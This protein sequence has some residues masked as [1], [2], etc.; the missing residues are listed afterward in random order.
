[1]IDEKFKSPSTNPTI[2]IPRPIVK[3]FQKTAYV[4][5]NIKLIIN[6]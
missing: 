6:D 2:E 3:Y 1:M 5:E 4:I